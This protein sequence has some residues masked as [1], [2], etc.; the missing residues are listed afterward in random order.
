MDKKETNNE[1]EKNK[2]IK[3]LKEIE[4]KIE[5]INELKKTKQKEENKIEFKNNNKE[6]NDKD[7]FINFNFDIKMQS[8][9]SEN[10]YQELKKLY[11]SGNKFDFTSLH[12]KNV[13]ENNRNNNK[14]SNNKKKISRIV[15]RIR[16]ISKIFIKNHKKQKIP[17]KIKI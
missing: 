10:K 17:K 8:G 11:F 7:N 4:V 9:N 3:K 16:L 12:K 15:I 5:G 6:N 2:F 14:D 1:K 13:K